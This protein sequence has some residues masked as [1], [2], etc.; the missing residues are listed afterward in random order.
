MW[1]IIGDIKYREWG[2]EMFE[3]FV[4]YIVVVDGG[5]FMSLYNVNVIFFIVKDNMESFWL[6]SLILFD[7]GLGILYVINLYVDRLRC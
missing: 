4:N 5:G 7:V 2:W 6:V 3:L 1:C